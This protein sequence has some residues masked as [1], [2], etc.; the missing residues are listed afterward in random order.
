MDTRFICIPNFIILIILGII[1][2]IHS[3]DDDITFARKLSE[4]D[5]GTLEDF[6]K[7]YSDVLYFVARKYCQFKPGEDHWQYITKSKKVINVSDCVADTYLWL[8]KCAQNKS[9]SFKGNKG[10]K[11][12]T[13]ISAVL[14]SNFTFI[15]WLK[16]KYG[17]TGY[18]PKQIRS[19][20]E[21]P[22][23]IYTYLR[24]NKS[25]DYIINKL[26]LDPVI[27][28]DIK[29]KILKTLEKCGNSYLLTK[30]TTVSLQDCFD[31]SG[32]GREKEI[33][34]TEFLDLE[35]QMQSA[36][37][38]KML[39]RIFNSLHKSERR[40]LQLY[41]GA[42]LTIDQIYRFLSANNN[43]EM[44]LN[45]ELKTPQNIYKVIDK[46]ISTM[47]DIVKT[48]YRNFY[49]D[50]HMTKE[51]LKET[52]KIYLHYWSQGE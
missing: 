31:D 12:S 16:W 1:D 14:N 2:A 43:K 44:D 5:K 36:R 26:G 27:Y 51:S 9:R 13:Y 28:D 48:E 41:W 37:I 52:V 39:Q 7:N 17:V 11:F 46:I 10:A 20:G 21:I 25:D 29:G 19:L 47:F 35:D 15:D 42:D 45:F 32:Q 33:K 3:K 6:L 40:L 8:V 18:I 38:A 50:Y 30:Y 34:D 4:G 23:N 24:Q 49:K 22:S